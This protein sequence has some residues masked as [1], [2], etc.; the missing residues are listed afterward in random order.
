MTIRVAVV[1]GGIIGCT[2]AREFLRRVPD[3]SVT[4]LEQKLVG[5][6]ASLYSAGLHLPRGSTERVRG[7]TKYSQEY[8]EAVRRERPDWPIYPLTLAVIASRDSADD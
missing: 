4:L 6:G 8:Y 7:M 2:I 3:A 1:G 5:T